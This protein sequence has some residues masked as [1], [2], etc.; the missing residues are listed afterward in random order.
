MSSKRKELDIKNINDSKDLPDKK[1]K[2]DIGSSNDTNNTNNNNNTESDEKNRNTDVVLKQLSASTKL[3]R[4]DTI[5]PVYLLTVIL[6]CSEKLRKL[7]YDYMHAHQALD[8]KHSV[9]PLLLVL[10]SNG[11]D[12]N[13]WLSLNNIIRKKPINNEY[14]DDAIHLLYEYSIYL[15]NDVQTVFLANLKQAVHN[16]ASFPRLRSDQPDCKTNKG[17]Y[18]IVRAYIIDGLIGGDR[19]CYENIISGMRGGSK[20]IILDILKYFVDK[21]RPHQQPIVEEPGSQ[22]IMLPSTTSMTNATSGVDDFQSI[23][24][25]KRKKKT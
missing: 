8:E 6:E 11:I 12:R 13:I 2:L 9:Y 7:S 16:G 5:P 10:P 17:S 20:N 14:Y 15:P 18:I 23:I 24:L 25:K 21:E 3:I 1:Q 19:A 22:N 4:V